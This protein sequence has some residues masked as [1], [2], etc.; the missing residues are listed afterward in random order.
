M[1]SQCAQCIPCYN[2]DPLFLPSDKDHAAYCDRSD[3]CT[4]CIEHCEDE[5]NSTKYNE[6]AFAIA[7][8]E[9]SCPILPQFI[10]TMHSFLIDDLSETSYQYIDCD[11]DAISVKYAFITSANQKNI[12]DKRECTLDFSDELMEECNQQS[13]CLFSN[14]DNL[15]SIIDSTCNDGNIYQAHIGIFC[16]ATSSNTGVATSNN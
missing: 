9:S 12:D 16:I 3:I 4:Q 14:F 11:A 5:F 7:G 2:D 8:I 15:S 10:S 1:E 13:T 6:N